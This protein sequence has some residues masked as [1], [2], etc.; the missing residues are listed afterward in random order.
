M[1]DIENVSSNEDVVDRDDVVSIEN[2][3][4]NED[5]VLVEMWQL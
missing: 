1:V 5:V 2:V 4:S 3:A